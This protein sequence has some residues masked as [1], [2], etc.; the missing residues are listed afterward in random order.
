MN[1]NK[2]KIILADAER[3]SK[4]LLAEQLSK[5]PATVRKYFTTSLVS[6]SS[7]FK[8]NEDKHQTTSCDRDLYVT[9]SNLIQVQP[10]K[11]SQKL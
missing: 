9:V 8:S 6:P 7:N 11:I 1:L 2:L 5:Y 10:L 4:L 3:T